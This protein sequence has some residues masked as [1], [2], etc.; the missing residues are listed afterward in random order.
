V[1][2]WDVETGIKVLTLDGNYT[3]VTTV[4]CSND[5][6]F[7]AA[8]YDVTDQQGQSVD[9]SIRIWRASDGALLKTLTEAGTLG[10]QS[11]AFAPTSDYILAGGDSGAYPYYF[12]HVRIWRV[13]DG[14]LVLNEEQ[15]DPNGTGISAV[16]SATYSPNGALIA[17]TRLDGLTTVAVNPI[18]R[19]RKRGN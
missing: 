15:Q 1:S 18:Q 5:G 8:G 6:N 10:V 14:E 13:S 17:F 12:G 16:M 7:I 9:A 3:N 4:A 2:V 11:I 19:T